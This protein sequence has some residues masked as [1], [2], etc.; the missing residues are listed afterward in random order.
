ML[1]E[2]CDEAA[3]LGKNHVG[4]KTPS[5]WKV[6]ED[7]GVQE[8]SVPREDVP[9]RTRDACELCEKLCP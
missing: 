1:L 9:A 3:C 5:S 6:K 2:E 8:S 7:C 4:R